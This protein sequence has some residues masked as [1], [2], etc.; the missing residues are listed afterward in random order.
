MLVRSF[1]QTVSLISLTSGDSIVAALSAAVAVVF[2]VGS[3][4]VLWQWTLSEKNRASAQA[5][6]YAAEIN[7]AHHALQVNN[8]GRARE[9]LDRHRPEAGQEDLRGWEWRHLWG[10]CQSDAM[11]RLVCADRWMRLFSLDAV[12]S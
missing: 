6:A 9:L 12:P 3:V 2:L 4:G 7:L 11:F 5:A 8:L 1:D 10:R